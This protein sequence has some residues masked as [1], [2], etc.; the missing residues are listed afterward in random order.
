MPSE[1]YQSLPGWIEDSYISLERYLC[2]QSEE[3]SF[4]HHQATELITQA[5]PDFND[6]D[7][8]TLSITYSTA[9]GSIKSTTRYSL[10]SCSAQNPTSRPN[11]CLSTFN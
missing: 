10:L 9:G 11:D 3:D 7:I 8:N 4:T 6:A 5:N 2:E 1:G